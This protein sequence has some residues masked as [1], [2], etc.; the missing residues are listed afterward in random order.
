MMSGKKALSEVV[1]IELM[2]P[3]A[4]R[5]TSEQNAFC[6]VQKFQK[7]TQLWIFECLEVKIVVLSYS[8]LNFDNF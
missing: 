4:F 3:P 2:V 1:K 8:G 7:L 5:E 6:P